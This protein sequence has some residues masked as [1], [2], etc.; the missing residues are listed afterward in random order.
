MCIDNIPYTA[1]EEIGV[2]SVV[3]P[4]QEEIRDDE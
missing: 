3:P 2:L 4:A 1:A